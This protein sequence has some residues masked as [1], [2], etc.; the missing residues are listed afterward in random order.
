MLAAEGT[1]I[2]AVL[3]APGITPIT[4][5]PFILV[6]EAVITTEVNPERGEDKLRIGTV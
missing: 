5:N 3:K 2:V 4:M 6:M 1:V